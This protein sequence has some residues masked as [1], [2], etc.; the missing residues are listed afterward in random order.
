[1]SS[2]VISVSIAIALALPGTALAQRATDLDGVLVT[3]TRTPIAIED[4]LLPAQVIDRTEIDRSQATSLPDL[5]RGRAGID[6]ASTGGMGQQTSLFMRGTNSGHVLVLIDGIRVGSATT[7]A[8]ALNDLPIGQVERIEIVRGSR[9]SLYGSEAIG[10]VIQIFTTRGHQGFEQNYQIGAGRHGLREASAGF[11]NH[12]ERGWIAVQGAYQKTDGINACHGTAAGWGTGCYVDEP[13]RDGY[14]NV[15]VSVRGGADLTE[16]L[17][18]EGHFLNAD[19][20]HEYDGD[21]YAGN[22]S[23]GVQRLFGGKLD[24]TPSERIHLALQIGRSN[25]GLDS[26]LTDPSGSPRSFVSRFDTRRDTASLQGDFTLAE[27]Q[28]LSVG[29]DWQNDRVTSSTAYDESERD[30]TGVFAEYQARFGAHQLQLSVRN[31]DNEQFGNHTTG[32]VGWGMLLGNGFKLNAS[33]GTGFKAP[34]FNDLYYPYYGNLDLDPEQSRSLNI[35]VAQYLDRWNWSLNLYET[36]I[37]DLIAY[38]GAIWLPNNIE[39]ARIRGAELTLSTSLAGFDISAQF[40]HTDPRNRSRSSLNHDNWLPRRARDTG[41]IDIDRGFGAWRFGITGNAAGHRYDDAANTVR[42]GGYATLD[43]RAEYA[44]TPEWS[45]QV[46]VTNVFD[47]EYE[48][49]AWYN[50]PDREYGINLRYRAKAE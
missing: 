32:S 34:T 48:T 11:S 49:V 38:D 29:A 20:F 26:Y 21:I 15:S 6:L 40:S 3:A 36:R 8:A 14:R 44:I 33:Y 7:G 1:M 45:V 42:L 18:V 23:N 41:R 31:D 10:G 19:T 30:N 37:D 13:D 47:R 22:E 46:R 28:L 27:N 24:W 35:G 50:Q 12:G 39:K 16:T 4:S 43:L 25:D 17:A 2:R 9:S 5:L